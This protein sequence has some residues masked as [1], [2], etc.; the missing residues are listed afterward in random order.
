MRIAPDWVPLIPGGPVVVARDSRTFVPDHATVCANFAA[1][2]MPLCLDW[3]HAL[4]HHELP[5]GSSKASGWID[6][7]EVRDDGALWGHVE[8]WT[9]SGKQSIESGEYR[10]ISPTMSIDP[11]TLR[12]VDLWNASLVN[13]PALIMPSL[14]SRQPA[15]KKSMNKHVTDLLSAFGLDPESATEAQAAEALALYQKGKAPMDEPTLASHVPV[16]QYE[17]L[18]AEL[19]V[20]KAQVSQHEEEALD[21]KVGQVIAAALQNGTLLPSEKTFFEAAAR[22]DLASVVELFSKRKPMA[23][24][25]AKSRTVPTSNELGLSE[26]EL[27]MAKAAN[28]TPAAFAAAKNRLKG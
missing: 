8:F 24:G 14:F 1:Q 27:A 6:A 2:N 4:N 25:P 5:P 18:A 26:K 10:F 22:K 11:E 21:A 20:L 19:A 17:A 28:I 16:E 3:D 15:K 23:G 7:L 9:P 12:V 13:D